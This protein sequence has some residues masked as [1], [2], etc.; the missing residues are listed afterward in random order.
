MLQYTAVCCSV[1]LCGAVYC[2]RLQC[3]A[4]WYSVLQCAA[5][6]FR[7]LQYVSVCC[8][9]LQCVAVC[10]RASYTLS[11]GPA[12]IYACMYVCV[13]ERARE[14]VSMYVS[15]CERKTEHERMCF[16]R[17]VCVVLLSQENEKRTT[18]HC[19]KLKHTAISEASHQSLCSTLGVILHFM[20]CF[21]SL[22]RFL[23]QEIFQEIC[24]K[25]FFSCMRV[26]L[27]VCVCVRVVVFSRNILQ[28]CYLTNVSECEWCVCVCVCACVCV[29]AFSRNV[30][31]RLL[32]TNG[33]VCLCVYV[34]VCA[35][36]C[37][38]VCVCFLKKFTSKAY[39]N[40]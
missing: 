36:V 27:C 38:C 5:V 15:A 2:Y 17:C 3:V 32:I 20:F 29:F 6:C 28:R 31:R 23:S 1:L 34:C 33:S 14:C 19:D 26:C 35:C 11:Q 13:C 22:C 40:K 7:V 39:S 37:V 9:V 25:G 10:C 21:L 16:C 30:L 4:V 18:T 8:S 12:R 24:C